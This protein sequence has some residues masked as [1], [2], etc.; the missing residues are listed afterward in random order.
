[1][2]TAFSKTRP[3]R[4]GDD[5]GVASDAIEYS[6]FGSTIDLVAAS[7]NA[8]AC[9]RAFMVTDTTAGT[10]LAVTTAKGQA[11]SLTINSNMVG[12]L[13]PMA[14]RSVTGGTTTISRVIFFW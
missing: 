12:K 7:A 10:V 13:I 2:S 4:R 3:G 8:D 5:I 14:V 11:R 9:P 1:M 6:A